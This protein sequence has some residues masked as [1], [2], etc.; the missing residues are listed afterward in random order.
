[1]SIYQI[2]SPVD[3]AVLAQNVSPMNDELSTRVYGLI[4]QHNLSP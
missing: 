1:M 3:N 2:S 4:A